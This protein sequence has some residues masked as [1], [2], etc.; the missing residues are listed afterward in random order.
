MVK[1]FLCIC[2]TIFFL[3]PEANAQSSPNAPQSLN[4]YVVRAVHMLSE[5]RAGLGYNDAALTH[6]LQFG[7]NG[8]LKASGPPFTMCVAA[9]LEVLVEAL[10][11]Y[12]RETNDFSAFHY[13]PKE[14]WER[15]RPL[16]FRGQIW[17]VD[18]SPSH[19][20][21]D[22]FVNYG[23]GERVAFKDMT[24]GSFLNLNRDNGT[25]HAVIFL[26]YLDKDGN[27]LKS[28]S[29]QVAGFEYFSSQGKGAPDGGLGYRWAFFS[30]KGCPTLP[31]NRKRDCGII[32]SENSNLLV[33]G[34]LKTPKAWDQG[35]AAEQILRAHEATEPELTTDGVFN[36]NFFN[37][38][39]TDD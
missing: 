13:I 10:N 35:K 19:G 26:S 21:A 2:V 16:D 15:L 1:F 32:H 31:G 11:L 37:G 22:A 33:G 4:N 18:H 17:I 8:I 23:M 24:P 12:A 3:S 38:V 29:A 5:T 20:A 30:D 34:Y 28:F 7:D 9:Q 36:L 27:E 6:D 39:T 25:G 14:S